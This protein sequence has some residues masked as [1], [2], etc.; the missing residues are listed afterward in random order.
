MSLANNVRDFI[1]FVIHYFIRASPGNQNLI[2]SPWIII[3]SIFTR[4]TSRKKVPGDPKNNF[5]NY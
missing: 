2:S 4:I 1:S 3:P 5:A